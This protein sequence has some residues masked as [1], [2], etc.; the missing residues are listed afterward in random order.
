MNTRCYR[1][2]GA[3]R[4]IFGRRY[5]SNATRLMRPRSSSAC[6]VVPRI[7]KS[8][9]KVR[10][11]RRAPA[12]DQVVLRQAAPPPDICL[13]IRR[14]L[15][16]CLFLLCLCHNPIVTCVV[17]CYYK[18]TVTFVLG[19]S[20]PTTFVTVNSYLLG[21]SVKVTYPPTY[22]P[23]NISPVHRST[24]RLAV[25]CALCAACRGL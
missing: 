17:D 21:I 22:D 5:L 13:E 24:G 4:R 6:F 18:P 2:H 1:S 12:L 14:S 20:F 9:Y 7:A 15:C 23:K 19:Y 16:S 10:R 25:P 8:C 3:C 11:V